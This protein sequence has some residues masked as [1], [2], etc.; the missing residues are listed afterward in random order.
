MKSKKVFI[1]G[2]SSD[3]GIGVINYFLANNWLVLAHYNQNKKSLEKM[4]D[5][6]PPKSNPVLA[7]GCALRG[8]KRVQMLDWETWDQ[9]EGIND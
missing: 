7:F 9:R 3:I 1:L 5:W 8:P 2:A 6:I 4:H